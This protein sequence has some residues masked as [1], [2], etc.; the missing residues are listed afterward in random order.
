MLSLKE[1][2]QTLESQVQNEDQKPSA[3]MKSLEI[4]TGQEI[5]ALRKTVVRRSEITEEI[6]GADEQ[7]KKVQGQDSTLPV[8][9]RD[10][11]P[12]V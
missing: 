3:S 1:K 7:E 5:Q 4:C 12:R 9:V 6:I 8:P 11:L 10:D 2:I